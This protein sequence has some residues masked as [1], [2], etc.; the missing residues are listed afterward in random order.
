M[1]EN[2]NE[3]KAL[4]KEYKTKALIMSYGVQIGNVSTFEEFKCLIEN[5]FNEETTKRIIDA[6]LEDTLS[7]REFRIFYTFDGEP[8]CIKLFVE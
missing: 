6:T 1:M 7:N 5:T 2:A 4:V 3:F 8:K